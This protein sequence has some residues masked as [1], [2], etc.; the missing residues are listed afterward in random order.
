MK[1]SL[2]V[3]LLFTF[4]FILLL[5]S[6]CFIQ[7]QISSSYSSSSSSFP[8]SSSSSSPP[9]PSSFSPFPPPS[10]LTFGVL[11][12]AQGDASGVKELV[13]QFSAERAHFILF[14]G[15][16]NEYGNNISDIDEMIEVF[17]ALSSANISVY[18]IPGNHENKMDYYTALASVNSSLL[19][20]LSSGGFYNAAG[21]DFFAVPGYYRRH[22]PSDAGF[23]Y[24]SFNL[25]V[26]LTSDPIFVL[27]HGPP[28]S[29]PRSS[30][31]L[32]LDLTLY[33]KSVG[34]PQ[35]TALLQQ[36][37]L[38]FGFFGHIHEDGGIAVDC[39]GKRVAENVWSD[40]LFL[41]PGSVVPWI[42]INGS[43]SPGSAAIVV[44]DVDKKRMKYKMVFLS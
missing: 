30:R 8:S 14:L 36:N 16:A 26:P 1:R 17:T 4:L 38:S 33:G 39:S 3:L 22:F 13:D 19:I 43:K 42:L 40:C 2:A 15:D 5:L 20:D 11:S 35:I 7:P 10:L 23:V 32:G 29:P 12:D 21:V 41:N 44:Y 27:S 24:D 18:A 28:Y 37:N 9:P 34:D 25:S 31:G 6:S